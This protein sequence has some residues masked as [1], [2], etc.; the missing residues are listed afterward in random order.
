MSKKLE[1]LKKLKNDILN[2]T[3]YS[4]DF[5]LSPEIEKSLS[6]NGIKIR[7]IFAPLL[8]KIYLTQTKYKL[9]K[10]NKNPKIKTNKGKIFVV[11][12]RQSDDIVLGANA[13][14]ESG[15]FV[16]GNKFLALDTTNG[17]GLWA[18]GM[19]LLDRDNP[20]NRK[21]TYE[22]M[23]YVIEHGGNIIIYPEGYWNLDD[24]GLADERHRADDHNSENWL[25]Q[26]LNIGAIRLAQETGSPII[27][28]IL[29]YDEVN[30]KKC[31]SLKGEPFYISKTDDIFERKN[32]LLE[33]MWTM[34]YDLMSKYS[35]YSRLE[36]EKNGITLKEQWEQL[37]KELISDCDIPKTGYKLDLKDEKRI[38]KAKSHNTITTNEEAFAHLDELIP[39]KENAFLLSKRL[40]GIKKD[41]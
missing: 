15:Y 5:L 31:Y 21:Q 27:P 39:K 28:T 14:G 22:K 13:I 11:N 34:Y 25:I 41:T 24:N 4:V 18:Y 37:K 40:T 9:I 1:T 35:T 16:F 26:D 20:E 29:H 38:G 3:S 17:L 33:K 19:I 2:G 10:E 8:R 7:K 36:L 12:H 23:K 32:I 30:G 6:E